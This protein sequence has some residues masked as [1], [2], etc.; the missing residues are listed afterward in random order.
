M[1]NKVEIGDVTDGFAWIIRKAQTI[2]SDIDRCDLEDYEKDVATEY[3]QT[4]ID[5]IEMAYR[6]LDQD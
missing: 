5:Y 3:L 6:L 2:L 4:G 1:A